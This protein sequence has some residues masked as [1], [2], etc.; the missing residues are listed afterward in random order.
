M[1]QADGM[2][3]HLPIELKDL[4]KEKTIIA[5]Q[6]NDD[7]FKKIVPTIR[8]FFDQSEVLII[9]F[10]KVLDR[11]LKHGYDFRDFVNEIKDAPKVMQLIEEAII[12]LQEVTYARAG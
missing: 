8:E 1:L 5:L 4:C 2:T 3:R 9:D 7:S 10:E 11:E 6:D 12:R